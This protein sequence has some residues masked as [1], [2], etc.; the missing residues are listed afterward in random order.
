MRHLLNLLYLAIGALLCTMCKPNEEPQQGPIS[1]NTNTLET[2]SVGG[3]FEL[4]YTLTFQTNGQKPVAK[5]DSEWVTDI[6]NSQELKICLRILPNNTAESR[7]ATLTLRHIGCSEI[8]S[9]TITQRGDSGEKLQI[10]ITRLDYSECQATITPQSPTMPYIVMMA[11]KAYFQ[12]AN[13][14]DAESLVEADLARIYTYLSEEDSVEEFIYRANMALR[15]T[16]TKQ[17]VDLSPAKEYIIYA[18][19]I[20]AKGDTYE[21]ITPVYYTTLTERMPERT[22]QHFTA[23]ISTEGPNATI[24]ITPENWQGYYMVQL[25]EDSQAGYIEQGLPLGKEFEDAVAESFFYISD[26]L[27]Y[28]EEQSPE[29][30]MQTLGHKG[31]ATITE[32]LNAD[33]RYMA[34]IYAID[35]PEGGIPMMVSNCTV[36]YFTTGSV[37]RSDM[38]FEVFFENIRPR[39]VDITIRPSTDE[40]YTAVMMYA[41]NMPDADKQ[42]QLDYVLDTYA[43]LELSGAYQEH[44]DQLPPAT[45]FII[46]VCGYYAGAPTTDL[47]IY[48]FTTAEDGEGENRITGIECKAY[49]LDE[50]AELEPYYSSFLGYADYFLSVE[51]T[52]QSPTPTLHFDIFPSRILEEYG[53]DAIRESLLEY[54]LTSSPDWALCTYGNEYVVCG[55][56]EDDRGYVG[57]M[58]VSEPVVFTKAETSDASHF[59]EL[60]KEYVTPSARSL[61]QRSSGLL[62]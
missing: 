38:T 8:A 15:G 57:E 30:I 60:Y 53:L 28:F 14:D 44:I 19:G 17:W 4:G 25:V 24:T 41:R 12:E 46:A 9:I 10:E 16:Q 21:R 36:T 20:Y 29:E 1:F 11:E 42:T 47:F 7:Q 61:S 56:A 45:D 2:E 59:V 34:I 49:D 58:Y 27:H 50:V 62:R 5:S 39:S 33:H 3:Y 23:D 52:T 40:S 6:D 35:T 32:S 37:E 18:Y 48:R 51:V 22:T 55:L 54:S 31:V 26:H 13:I 43:P